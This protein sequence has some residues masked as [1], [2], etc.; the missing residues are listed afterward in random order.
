MV[1]SVLL[2]SPK[3]KKEK[4]HVAFLQETHLNAIEQSKLNKMGF[5]HVFSSSC[6]SSHKRGVANLIFKGVRHELDSELKD[7][8]GRLI[9]IKGK[10]NGALLAFMNIY[11]PLGS[12]S[13]FF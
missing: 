4:A 5:K 3:F 11:A 8:I 9:L 12:K 10:I 1:F 7:K 6:K 13:N 2:K